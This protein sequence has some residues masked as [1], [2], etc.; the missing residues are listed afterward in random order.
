[1]KDRNG[2]PIG[3]GDVVEVVDDLSAGHATV[4]DVDEADDSYEPEALIEFGWEDGWY[5]GSELR[6]V[7]R[8]EQ[9]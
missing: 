2:D 3:V 7:R 9:A 6:L 1:V 4:V 8:K 5:K